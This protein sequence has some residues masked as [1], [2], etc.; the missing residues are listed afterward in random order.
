MPAP[1]MCQTPLPPPSLHARVISAREQDG[2]PKSC[3]GSAL[4]AEETV[5]RTTSLFFLRAHR[6][7]HRRDAKTPSKGS[8]MCSPQWPAGAVN[9]GGAARQGSEKPGSEKQRYGSHQQQQP[10]STSTSSQKKKSTQ[11][12]APE[13]ACHSYAKTVRAVLTTPGHA[14]LLRSVPVSGEVLRRTGGLLGV[15]RAPAGFVGP[16]VTTCG[17]GADLRKVGSKL[18]ACSGR[19]G[20]ASGCAMGASAG[21]L[22]AEVGKNGKVR[23]PRPVWGWWMRSAQRPALSLHG[24]CLF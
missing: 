16:G 2:R 19:A 15:G 3:S 23:E 21:R 24:V 20:C 22:Q 18:L 7:A 17:G 8:A 9:W 1:P 13:P 11:E 4:Q 6:S 14:P 12:N 10:A 5:R